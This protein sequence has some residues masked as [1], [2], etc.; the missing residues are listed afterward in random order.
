[1]TKYLPKF[2]EVSDN[3]III[4]GERP[5]LTRDGSQFALYGNRTG[6]FVHEAIDDKKNLILTNLYNVLHEGDFDLR[7]VA[8]GVLDLI[9][10]IEIYEPSLIVTLGK[11]AET[12][13]QSISI[14]KCPIYSM[15]HP[16]W[17]NRFKSKYRQDYINQLKHELDK[18]VSTNT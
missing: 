14:I 5:G 16:S 7:H 9:E 3:P 18:R 8:D 12:Y 17:I 11:P 10:L 4:V 15:P 2:I 1:M 6:D 13:V